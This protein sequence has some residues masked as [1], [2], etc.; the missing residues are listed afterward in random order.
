METFKT[1]T[2]QVIYVHNKKDCKGNYCVVHNPSDHHMRD[3]PLHWRDD[4][5]IFERI[6]PHGI[7]H[8]DPDDMAYKKSIGHPDEG[9][10]GCDG[11]CNEQIYINK[12]VN[13]LMSS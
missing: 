11:C 1:D 12:Q 2:G 6:C 13:E 3:W 10:H 8:P 7:G 5:K 4:R 9:I